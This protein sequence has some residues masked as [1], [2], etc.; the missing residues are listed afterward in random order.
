MGCW[1]SMLP[2]P[3]C[4]GC[5]SIPKTEKSSIN[6]INSIDHFTNLWSVGH[7]TEMHCIVRF[8]CPW[9]SWC[10]PVDEPHWLHHFQ[11]PR[12]THHR[13]RSGNVYK[14]NMHKRPFRK[15]SKTTNINFI[16]LGKF[17]KEAYPCENGEKWEDHH[18]LHIGYSKTAWRHLCR[19]PLSPQVDECYKVHE[20]PTGCA[21]EN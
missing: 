19:A 13:P 14:L 7:Q 15:P 17:P 5:C 21:L 18:G 3:G 11:R 20:S 1:K 8:H 10:R 6:R 2:T 9:N 16:I 12:W 4:E